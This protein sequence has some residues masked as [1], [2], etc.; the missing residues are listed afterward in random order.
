MRSLLICCLL[1]LSGVA[2]AGGHDAVFVYDPEAEVPPL[3]PGSKNP[4]KKWEVEPIAAGVYGFRYTFYRTIFIVTDK[5]VIV[6]DP[7]NAQAA[8]ILNTEIRRL[9]DLPVQYVA[10]SHSHWDHASGAQVFA[11]QGAK[12]VAQQQCAEQ[13]IENPNPNIISPNITF[14]D[15]YEIQLG[16][17]A[18]EMLYFGPSH[19]SCMVVMVVK[20]ANLLFM[21][22]LAN[23][24]DGWAM[25]YNPAVSEDRVWHMVPFFTRVQQLV[26]ERKIEGVIGAHMTMGKD[27]VTGKLGIIP[28]TL[29]PASVIA[30][31]LAFWSA[32]IEIVTAELAAGTAPEQVPDRLVAQG[33]L[34]DQISG[35]D[36]VKMRVLLQRITS[37][38]VTGE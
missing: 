34:T 23:P 29:G 38:A 21:V 7:L 5:G 32:L 30:E 27:P 1:T 13:F 12:V 22:D 35:Y 28:G 4:M 16:D 33:A 19:D 17:K 6:A 14:T 15:R 18:L 11:E 3:F 8:E 37:Y 36:P 2:A 24:P 9:T 20:P 10:Y 25:F 26:E 31:R